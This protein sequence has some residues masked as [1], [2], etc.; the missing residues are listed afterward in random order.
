MNISDIL[1]SDGGFGLPLTIWSLYIGISIAIAAS[2][3]VKEKIG[4]FARLLLERKANS[5]ETALTLEELDKSSRWIKSSLMDHKN[6]KGLFVACLPDG[7][8]YAN[9]RYYDSLPKFKQY[10]YQTKSSMYGD[11][12]KE[13]NKKED[14]NAIISEYDPA[15]KEKITFN[16]SECK[17]FI[18]E[19]YHDK[20]S[21]IYNSK[22]TK[23]ILVIIS[24]IAFGILMSFAENIITGLTDSLNDFISSLDPG[25]NAI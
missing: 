6:Y 17:F 5:P 13:E 2:Y 15:L 4:K 7:R 20:V 1:I 18:P 14:E 8:Y 23:I 19:E 10:V 16:P 25:N 21:S 12:N 24:I 22:P 11:E 3:L 9:C